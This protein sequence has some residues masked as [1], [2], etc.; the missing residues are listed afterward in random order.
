MEEKVYKYGGVTKDGLFI[1]SNNIEDFRIQEFV[2]FQ[3]T[4]RMT[5]EEINKHF[6]R[7]Y[8]LPKDFQ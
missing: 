6:G 2:S 3:V 7:Y 5:A 4:E 1:Q 8:P